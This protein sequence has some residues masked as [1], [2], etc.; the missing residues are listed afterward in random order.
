MIKG[1]YLGRKSESADIYKLAA[2]LSRKAERD[3][4]VLTADI[5]QRAAPKILSLYRKARQAGLKLGKLAAE[6]AACERLLKIEHK[7]QQIIRQANKDCL[8]LSLSVAEEIIGQKISEASDSLISR[9]NSAIDSLQDQRTIRITVNSA[10]FSPVQTAL[11][12]HT[13]SGN[14]SLVTSEEVRRGNALLETHSGKIALEWEQHLANLRQK[15]HT[16]LDKK[17]FDEAA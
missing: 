15:L 1:R 17:F 11:E 5:R 8:N 2:S 13:L 9:I 7:Y 10:D 14:I 12:A 6:R 4:E 16:A 3:A